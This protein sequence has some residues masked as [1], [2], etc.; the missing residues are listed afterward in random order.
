VCLLNSNLIYEIK[1]I[2]FKGFPL[3]F[4][5]AKDKEYELRRNLQTHLFSSEYRH[6]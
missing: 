1:I 2:I 4:Q 6:F 5:S 3:Y